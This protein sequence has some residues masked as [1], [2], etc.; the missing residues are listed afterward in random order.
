MSPRRLL[1]LDRTTFLWCALGLAGAI[2]L[3]VGVRATAGTGRPLVGVMAGVSTFFR[4]GLTAG[5][6]VAAAQSRYGVAKLERTL[7]AAQGLLPWR[8]M[9]F[10][11][12]AYEQGVLSRNGPSYRF[13]HP[14]LAR[15]LASRGSGRRGTWSPVTVPRS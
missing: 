7:L 3:A 11:D 14:L 2:G 15:R 9:R 13:R 4:Y 6:T 10:L 5:V 12:T 8:F 1:C